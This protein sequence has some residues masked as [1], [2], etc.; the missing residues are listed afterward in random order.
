MDIKVRFLSHSGYLIE[1]SDHFILFDYIKGKLPEF[2]KPTL[3][4]STHSHDDHFNKDIINIEG[5][6]KI[7]LSSDIKEKGLPFKENVFYIDPDTN[8]NIGD[9][10][11]TTFRSTDKGISI[12]VNVD[13]VGIFHAGDLNLW[14]WDEDSASERK[15]MADEFDSIIKKVQRTN[16]EIAMFPLDP[17]LGKYATSGIEYF[18]NAVK[19][20]HLF[21]M[22]MWG[23]FSISKEFN[24]KLDTL[25]VEFY[26]VDH[27]N[28]DFLVE[29]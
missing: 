5:P 24:D 20:R 23:D 13:N 29:V 11:I 12:F 2:T 6:T 18:S 4:V 17:R 15:D 14:I 16:V 28:Q 3:I 27:D 7:L 8:R 26:E 21:P 22:H 25:N 9:F 10:K 1:T 19:P